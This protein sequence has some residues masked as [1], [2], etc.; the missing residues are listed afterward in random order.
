MH[1]KVLHTLFFALSSLAVSAQIPTLTSTSNPQIGDWQLVYTTDSFNISSTGAAVTW[2]YSTLPLN[3]TDTSYADACSASPYCSDF[4]G[5]TIYGHSQGSSNYIYYNTSSTACSV[6]GA[7]GTDVIPYSNY[8]DFLRY[9]FTYSSSYVDTFGATFVGG[10]ET[11]NRGG[12][13]TV[14][15]DGYGTLILPN[16]TYTNALRIH[17]TESY[18]DSIMGTVFSSYLSEIYTWYVPN[19]RQVLLSQTTFS[20]D[21][22]PTPTTAFYTNQTPGSIPSGISTIQAE[23]L[24]FQ[25][26]PNP[27][28]DELNIDFNMEQAGQVYISLLDIVGREVA[29][30]SNSNFNNGKQHLSYAT[31]ALDKGVYIVKIQ[32]ANLT[33]VKKIELL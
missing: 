12:T 28:R 15:A 33:A 10:A 30:I 4:P 18:A 3:A 17:R 2:D 1:K 7:Y 6:V 16:G 5:T 8:E 11:F 22:M 29:I 13:I 21:G 26:Y 19:A 23:P 9:P 31:T 24:T 27:V 20:I 32:T 14:T 25:L